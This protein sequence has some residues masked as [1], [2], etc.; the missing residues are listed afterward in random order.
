MLE[1]EV[2]RRALLKGMGAGAGLLA[3]G[4]LLRPG[5]RAAIR[6]S[7]G[8]ASRLAAVTAGPGSLP[9][10]SLAEGTD[11][12]PH[13]EHIIILMME[14]HSYDNYLGV[15]G[16][17]D[18]FTLGPNGLPT[19]SNPDAAGHTV[20]ATHAANLCQG[21]GVS[22]TW[23]ASHR[24]WDNGRNDGFVVASSA[25]AMQYWNR[26]DLPVYYAMASTF[27]LCDRWFCSVMAQTF[28]N[29][30]FLQAGTA[31]GWVADNVPGLTD[32]AP[33]GSIFDSLSA[34]GISW[35][36]YFVD[37]PSTGLFPYQLLH[38]AGNIQPVSNF[39]SDAAA[40]T[41]PSVSMIDPGFTSSSEEDPQDIAI[42]AAY[43]ANIFNAVLSSPCWPSTA[44]IW[45]YDEHGGYYD[46]VPPAPAV[47]PDNILPEITV[48]PDLPGGYNYTGFRVPAVVA[49]PW[50]RP[51]YV[52]HVVH[53]HT[54]FL[55][56]V[57]TKWNLPALTFRDANADNLLD[58]F[59]FNAPAPPFLK[60]PKLPSPNLSP[61]NLLCAL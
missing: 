56:L 6:S 34:H 58:C 22:Q 42:G 8:A 5:A 38:Y 7:A 46:H 20:V 19:N 41:L 55:K 52:S 3:A 50:A 37:V 11:T 27:P 33:S 32:R 17:G 29:R 36:N 18:G 30:R 39:F 23:D 9:Y 10:P 54:S 26:D 61:G 28:P 15:L 47:P 44:F 49:S 60:P 13:I 53:D 4:P 21:S 2:S 25:Q 43:A 31:L 45:T 57:E 40:G 12:I 24:A 59:N 51:N 1:R 14:N 48:P 16:R 35:K